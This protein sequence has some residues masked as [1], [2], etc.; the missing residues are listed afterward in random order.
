MGVQALFSSADE[1]SLNNVATGTGTVKPCQGGRQVSWFLQAIGV[2]TGGI[3]VFEHNEVG[4][5]YT[6]TWYPFDTQN[7]TTDPMTDAVRAPG[8]F[9]G[10]LYW[11]RWRITSAITGG[12]TITGRVNGLRG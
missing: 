10:T 6:G 1:I 11:V 3:V 4:P 12:G 2:C 7:F 9:P 5:T 8:T